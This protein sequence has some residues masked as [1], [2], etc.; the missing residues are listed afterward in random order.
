MKA[1]IRGILIL[2]EQSR[3]SFMER[4]KERMDSVFEI[5]N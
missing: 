3:L 2:I 1:G 5:F 4:E